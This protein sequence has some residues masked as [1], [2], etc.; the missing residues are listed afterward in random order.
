MSSTLRGKQLFV[1]VLALLAAVSMWFYVRRISVPRQEKDAARLERPRGNLSD[2]YPRW[3]GARELLLHGR[4]PYSREITLE[5]QRGYYGRE[6]GPSRPNDPKDENGFAYPVYVVFLLAPTVHMDFAAA[7]LLVLWLLTGLTVLS[8]LLWER[9]LGLELLRP[10]TPVVVLLLLGS[11][12]F[13]EAISLQQPILFVAALLAGSFLA[14]QCGWLFLSGVLLAVASIKPQVVLLPGILMLMWVSGNWRERQRLL[15]GFGSTMMLLAGAAEYILPGW[16]FRFYDAVRAYR[17]YMGGTSFLDWLLTPRWSALGWVLIVFFV[18]WASWKSRE[19]AP[20]TVASRRALSL[21]LVAVVCTAPNLAT[22]NQV[23]LLP[24]LLLAFE[25]GPTLRNAMLV[26]NLKWIVA[27]L[28]VWPWVACGILITAGVVFRAEPFVQRMW[29]LPLYGTLAL[30]VALLAFLFAV[31]SDG[32]R[33]GG[34]LEA[35]RSVP[36]GN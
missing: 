19:C 16:L 7:R 22:Y 8:V 20:D 36:L 10:H 35:A 13:V 9:I 32:D 25:L 21:V 27:G 4:D 14:R 18:L 28:L 5:I 3:L 34:M 29:Q 30:P 6:I 26:R 12:P 24:G 23:L 31:P 2:L 33:Q 1:I 11:Y 15:W 17:S